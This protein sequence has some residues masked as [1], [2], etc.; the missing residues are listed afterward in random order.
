VLGSL[1]FTDARSLNR[2]LQRSHPA[3]ASKVR[4]RLEARD[5]V[6][7]PVPDRKTRRRNGTVNVGGQKETIARL[8]VIEAIAMGGRIT[9]SR[10]EGVDIKKRTERGDGLAAPSRFRLYLE[11]AN[12]A[13]STGLEKSG[14]P[15]LEAVGT[16]TRDSR[17]TISTGKSPQRRMG[18]YLLKPSRS[19]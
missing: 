19:Q 4:W 3:S 11:A 8:R 13:Q 2:P 17:K 5:I 14:L 6:T 1:E 10:S 18:H 15:N 12:V 9:D 7:D 16:V